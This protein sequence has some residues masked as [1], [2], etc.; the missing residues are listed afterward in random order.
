M[1]QHH[2]RPDGLP[3]T[4][5]Y[6]HVVVHDGPGVLVSGQ[7]PLDRDGNLVG[8]GD[9][10]RQIT[11]VFTNLATALAAA[12]VGMR[13]VVKLTVYL[14]DRADLAA[15]R[16]V[17]DRY[18]DTSRPPACSLVFVQGLV[19]PDFRVEIDALAAR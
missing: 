12:G 4:N 14:T 17:R 13:D 18:I 15:F 19:S 7:V 9:A 8:A 3:P 16:R 11:Q 2:L 1:R 6:S 5:G 10:E